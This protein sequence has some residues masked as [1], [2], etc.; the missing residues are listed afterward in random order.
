[1]R[2]QGND[3]VE[4][5]PTSTEPAVGC[6]PAEG[7]PADAI[8][9]SVFAAI[10][11]LCF[12]AYTFVFGGDLYVGNDDLLLLTS[13]PDSGLAAVVEP[14]STHLVAVPY[15]IQAVLLNVFGLSSGIPYAAVAAAAWIAGAVG[16]RVIA[17]Q[18]HVGPWISTVVASSALF[19]AVIYP[20][21]QPHSFQVALAV[22]FG[23]A[24]VAVANARVWSRGK[25]VAVVTL[26][27]LALATS[28]VAASFVVAAGIVLWV[29]R[30]LRSAVI[31]LLLPTLVFATWYLMLGSG[32]LQELPLSLWDQPVTLWLQWPKAGYAAALEALSGWRVLAAVLAVTTAAGMVVA[33]RRT[34][35]VTLA[36]PLALGAAGFL[37]LM[38]AMVLRFWVG[39]VGATHG[40]FVYVT[41]L[42]LLPLMAVAFGALASVWRPLGALV[43]LLAL[44]VPVNLAH[45]R[46]LQALAVAETSDSAQ[47]ITALAMSPDLDRVPGWVRPY[48]NNVLLND[49]SALDVH[50]VRYLRDTGRLPVGAAPTPV[51]QAQTPVRLGL[52]VVDNEPTSPPAG[53]TCTRYSGPAIIDEAPGHRFTV[54][55]ATETDPVAIQA[56]IEGD[57]ASTVD[58]RSGTPMTFEVMLPATYVLQPIGDTYTLCR[59]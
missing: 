31:L 22:A 8:A 28:A 40:R 38:N 37:H 56:A 7:P 54:A 59:S 33:W 10:A 3:T 26:A 34:E 49:L 17:R 21:V 16:V 32:Q 19:C 46:D 20:Y 45:L 18:A 39:P 25:A 1:M 44:P 42:T 29:R 43:L 41:V 27:L 24:L 50:F 58:F 51:R 57:D 53:T 35:L 5:S 47:S 9:T 6:P 15:V 13:R 23:F 36:A 11:M 30:G 48:P 12:L 14:F 4:T 55:G 2:G 52:A